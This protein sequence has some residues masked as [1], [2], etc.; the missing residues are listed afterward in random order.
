MSAAD[1][2][3]DSLSYDSLRRA[4]VILFVIS[5][6][7]FVLLMGLGD[8][9]SGIKM[10]TATPAGGPSAL[11]PTPGLGT[12]MPE[13]SSV[14]S[15]GGS[16]ATLLTWI[17][18]ITSVASLLGV[19]STTYLGWR[20]EAREAQSAERERQRH[21]L[22]MERLRRELGGADEDSGHKEEN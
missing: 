7:T 6:I 12:P 19:I 10:A 1:S 3:T 4:L 17:S 20:K 13:D 8:G 15:G 9:G 16:S 2:P 14:V 5:T 18:L 21:E 22:E 11:T